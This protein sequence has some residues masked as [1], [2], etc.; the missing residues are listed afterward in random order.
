MC[1]NIYSEYIILLFITNFIKIECEIKLAK[2]K[3][4]H[5]LQSAY[6]TW[7]IGR[8]ISK[9]LQSAFSDRIV[10]IRLYYRSSVCQDLIYDEIPTRLV[11]KSI[12]NERNEL[13]VRLAFSCTRSSRFLFWDYKGRVRKLI[14]PELSRSRSFVKTNSVTFE[15]ELS[16]AWTVAG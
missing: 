5:R 4:T 14:S 6:R 10:Q 2:L 15:H 11:L 1:V 13:H 8:I 12:M 9:K 3:S 16:F 7:K